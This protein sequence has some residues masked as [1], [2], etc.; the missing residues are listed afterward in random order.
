[1]HKFNPDN[2][3]ALNVTASLLDALLEVNTRK[4]F[5]S[6]GERLTFAFPGARYDELVAAFRRRGELLGV[7]KVLVEGFI[8]NIPLAPADGGP[9][10]DTHPEGAAFLDGR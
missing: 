8:Q 10:G 7:D 6:I 5:R 1:M 4:E 2:P 3:A 9:E